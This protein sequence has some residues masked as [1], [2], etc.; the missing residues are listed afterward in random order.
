MT[1]TGVRVTG[2][3]TVLI[4]AVLFYV[5]WHSMLPSWENDSQQAIN[6][7]YANGDVIDEVAV[8]IGI[9]MSGV[10]AGLFAAMAAGLIINGWILVCTGKIPPPSY[11]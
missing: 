4:G 3:V 6:A 9:G 5:A 2:I 8:R 7:V 1:T 11:Y 10:A